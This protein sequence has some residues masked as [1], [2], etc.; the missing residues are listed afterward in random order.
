MPRQSFQRLVMSPSIPRERGGTDG[1]PLCKGRF[2]I[3]NSSVRTYLAEP[4]GRHFRAWFLRAFLELAWADRAIYVY[5]VAVTGK[6]GNGESG[7]G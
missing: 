4:R 1:R 5:W 2:G 7:D 6:C 3:G